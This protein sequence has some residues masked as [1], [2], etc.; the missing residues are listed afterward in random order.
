MHRSTL[1]AVSRVMTSRSG[2][3]CAVRFGQRPVVYRAWPDLPPMF[4]DAV[5]GDGEQPRQDRLPIGVEPVD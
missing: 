5:L 2:L 1:K 3:C 4:P